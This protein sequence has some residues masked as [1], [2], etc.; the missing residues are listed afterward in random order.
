MLSPPFLP[1]V[2]ARLAMLGLAI[3]Q[4]IAQSYAGSISVESAVG[5]GSTFTV[6]LPAAIID[7]EQSSAALT[8]VGFLDA[9][10]DIGEP[11]SED[12]HEEDRNSE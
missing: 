12:G 4:S 2:L 3:A 10:G 7:I 11:V 1:E 5:M 6:R 8:L 9:S